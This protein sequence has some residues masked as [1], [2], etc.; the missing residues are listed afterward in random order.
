MQGIKNYFK[1]KREKKEKKKDFCFRKSQLF[2]LAKLHSRPPKKPMGYFE[3]FPH[4]L[5]LILVILPFESIFG[6]PKVR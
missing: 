6:Q 5:P 2:P 4:K 1:K 3:D